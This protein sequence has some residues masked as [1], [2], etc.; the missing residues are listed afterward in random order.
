[1][2]TVV[3]GDITT[4][5]KHVI[6]NIKGEYNQAFIRNVKGYRELEGMNNLPPPILG[7]KYLLV[8]DYETNTKGANQLLDKIE[9][10]KDNAYVDILIRLFIKGPADIV[11][12]CRLINLSRTRYSDFAEYV[13]KDLDV[14][15]SL[16]N[17]IVKCIG[18]NLPT[19]EMYRYELEDAK[20]LTETII[21]KVI[22]Y[23]RVRPLHETLYG[24]LNRE[25]K[26]YREFRKSPYSESWLSE[27]FVKELNKILK[28]KIQLRNRDKDM[29]AI[30]KNDSTR[31]YSDIVLNIPI[32]ECAMM[33]N[34]LTENKVGGID[35]YYLT[36]NIED[37]ILRKEK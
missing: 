2:K 4:Y 9:S 24:L 12:K 34:M 28:L 36:T 22:K 1:M 15:I 5:N 16:A 8:L 37:Y 11:T 32:S 19:Y 26:A 25:P 3:I 30:R 20:P 35:R 33:R 17:T 23:K 29:Y 14:S 31:K 18:V 6:D 7:Y 27:H 10:L 13:A 21:R